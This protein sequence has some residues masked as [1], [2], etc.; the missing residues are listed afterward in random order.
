MSTR[1]SSKVAFDHVLDKV[2]ARGDT[3]SL[4]K[5]LTQHGCIDI[6]ALMLLSDDVI[7]SLNYD[8]PEGEGHIPLLR[9]EK[10]LISTFL[11]FIVHRKLIRKMV[12]WTSRRKNSMI[13]ESIPIIWLVREN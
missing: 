4:K 13:F 3:T 8:D 9:F 11:D 7:S 5:S 12:G 10:A 6:H 1:A 2:L